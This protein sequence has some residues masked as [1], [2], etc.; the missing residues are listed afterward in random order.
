MVKSCR[1]VTR[2]HSLLNVFE[3]QKK[4]QLL[5][6]LMSHDRRDPYPRYLCNE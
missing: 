6:R 4:V 2:Q 5:K 1:R 3:D